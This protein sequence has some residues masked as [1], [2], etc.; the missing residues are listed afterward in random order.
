LG[1]IAT[2]GGCTRPLNLLGAAWCLPSHP[3]KCVIENQ[4]INIVHL[5]HKDQ[6]DALTILF[7]VNLVIKR[8]MFRVGLLLIIRRYYSVYAA[9]GMCHAFM[10][11]GC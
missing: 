2:G 7:S 4:Q 8:Y 1:C 3:R 11:P 9:V 5:C 6:Q 10:L